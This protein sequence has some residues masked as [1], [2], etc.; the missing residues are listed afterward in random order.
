MVINKKVK[1]YQNV[2]NVYGIG[3]WRLRDVISIIRAER[4]IEK[5]EGEYYTLEEVIKELNIIKGKF[6][7]QIEKP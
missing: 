7:E 2:E 4:E 6:I 1:K 3:K 5:G